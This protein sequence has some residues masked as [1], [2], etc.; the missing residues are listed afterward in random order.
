MG[1]LVGASWALAFRFLGFAKGI[2]IAEMRGLVRLVW[3]GFWMNLISGA[4]MFIT[5][6]V[7]RGTAVMFWVKIA[8]V[9]SGMVLNTR[10]G[11]VFEAAGGG[12]IAAS[13]TTARLGYA[14]LVVW[15]AAVTAGRLIAYVGGNG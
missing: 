13:P 15:V 6:P 14:S 1:I 11:R 4:V 3:I 7:E 8:L 5:H 12:P 10:V 9:I 2:P